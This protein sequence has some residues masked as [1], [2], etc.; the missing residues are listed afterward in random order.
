MHPSHAVVSLS[1]P[2]TRPLT[3]HSLLA[4]NANL[5]Q[6]VTEKSQKVTEKSQ[7]S[8]R[9]VIDSQHIEISDLCATEN[10]SVI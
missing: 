4:M 6:R 9:K 3:Y 1:I 8:H 5:S 7:K 10:G 2:S